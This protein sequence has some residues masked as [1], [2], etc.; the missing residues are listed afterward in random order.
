M[1]Q[2]IIDFM[3]A[4]KSPPIE[5]LHEPGP[6]EAQIETLLKVATRV[7]DHGRLEPWRFI[8]YRGDARA[9][10]GR[11]IVE[12]AVERE[13]PLPKRGSRRNGPASRARRS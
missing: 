12:R 8:L 1:R 11:L 6:T 4:R 9:A 10:V 7:P 3:L 13:G 2:D 5:E